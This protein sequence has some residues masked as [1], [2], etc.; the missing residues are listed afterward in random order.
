MQSF[1]ESAC[2]KLTHPTRQLDTYLEQRAASSGNFVSLSRQATCFRFTRTNPAPAGTCERQQHDATILLVVN[3]DCLAAAQRLRTIHQ[4]VGVLNM[5][6]EFNTGGAFSVHAGSQEEYL[7]RNSSIGLSL[8]PHR[9]PELDETRPW[10][11]GTKLVGRPVPAPAEDGGARGAHPLP[12]L[13]LECISLS[14]NE[15]WYPWTELGGVMTPQVEVF[16]IR[17]TPLPAEAWFD[18]VGLSVAAQDLRQRPG[19]RN[20]DPDLLREKVRTLLYMAVQSNCDAL[21]LGALGCGAFLNPPEAVARAF[22]E[23]L[24][25]E[26]AEFHRRFATVEFAI[27][28]SSENLSAFRRQFNQAPL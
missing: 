27:I 26:E 24:V 23:L 28:K 22:W 20:F 10:A 3:E 8:W 5:A 18:I 1:L 4:R 25:P 19:N 15:Q 12:H 13:P 21:V 14:G 17:D 16:S 2:R 6:N 9:R 7:F 11:L